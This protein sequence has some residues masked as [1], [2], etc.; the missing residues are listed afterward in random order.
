VFIFIHLA[1]TSSGAWQLTRLPYIKI[2]SFASGSS[3]QPGL[4]LW[5]DKNVKLNEIANRISDK[6]FSKTAVRLLKIKVVEHCRMHKID[7]KKLKEI[8]NK[9]HLPA[10]KMLAERAKNK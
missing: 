8:E 1:L 6:E 10:T 4:L 9:L 3:K 2:I 5:Y 7:F